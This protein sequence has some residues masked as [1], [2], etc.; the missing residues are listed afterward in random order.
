MTEEI[1]KQFNEA[2]ELVRQLDN[3]L[4]DSIE[5]ELAQCV[6]E[7]DIDGLMGIIDKL[8]KGCQTMR[9]IYQAILEIE[10]DA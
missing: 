5:D 8:P 3:A 6:S 1:A 2:R 9:C 10:A 7:K 4:F